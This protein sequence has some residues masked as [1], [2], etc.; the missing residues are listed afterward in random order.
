M[1]GVDGDARGVFLVEVNNL[2]HLQRVIST[3][4]RVKGVRAVERTQF[5]GEDE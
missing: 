2:N 3:L 1:H 5:T 4:K